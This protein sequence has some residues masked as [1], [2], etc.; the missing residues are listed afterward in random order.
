MLIDNI[1]Q[2]MQQNPNFKC[3][4]DNVKYEIEF[5]GCANKKCEDPEINCI[6][7]NQGGYDFIESID[8]DDN[9]IIVYVIPNNYN[10]IGS[11]KYLGNFLDLDGSSKEMLHKIKKI[12]SNENNMV[13]L[14]AA[15]NP[16][17][18]CLHFH[19]LRQNKQSKYKR[20]YDMNE[21]G[22]FLQQDMYIDTVI[23]NL[24]INNN[25]YKDLNFNLIKSY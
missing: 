18:Y 9:K 6:Y 13:F 12:Y 7:Y 16:K 24:E 14:H 21:G 19:I 1:L 15:F 3:N 2:Y 23:N 25:Y 20:D 11:L 17:F 10:K 8:N 5:K 4:V 22:T